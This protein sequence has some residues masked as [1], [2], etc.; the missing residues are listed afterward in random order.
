MKECEFSEQLIFDMAKRG[1]E[2]GNAEF[3]IDPK[4]SALL[5]IDIFLL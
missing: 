5:V 4:N 1:Y 3:N 2:Q